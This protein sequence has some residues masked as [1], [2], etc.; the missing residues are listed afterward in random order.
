MKDP[1]YEQD[2]FW[3][4][5]FSVIFQKIGFLMFVFTTFHG[6]GVWQAVPILAAPLLFGFNA[7]TLHKAAISG[8]D[9]LWHA[10][11]RIHRDDATRIAILLHFAFFMLAMSGLGFYGQSA[12]PI[13]KETEISLQ[14]FIWQVC[15]TGVAYYAVK[16]ARKRGYG[17]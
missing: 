5:I 10:Q 12:V 2:F 15:C 1:V 17:Q 4:M 7:Y 6:S 11:A 16:L 3:L 8:F 9:L 14:L 13:S